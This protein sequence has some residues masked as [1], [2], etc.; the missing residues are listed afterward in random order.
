M[1]FTN[2]HRGSTLLLLV[3]VAGLP[4]PIAAAADKSLAAS[5]ESSSIPPQLAQDFGQVLQGQPVVLDITV[6]NKRDTPLTIGSVQ[7]MCSCMTEKSD[8]SIAPGKT[9]TISLRLETADYSGPVTEAA[10]IQWVDSAVPVTRVELKLDVKPVLQVLPKKL[11]RFKAALGKVVTQS[12]DLKAADG[13]PFKVTGVETSKPFL[14]AAAVAAGA[15]GYR[16]TITLGADAPAGMLKETVTVRTDI[17]TLPSLTLN[18]TGIVVQERQASSTA[19]SA[20]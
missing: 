14:K 11:V 19:G 18:V 4:G 13:K 2:N 12:V 15:G 1:P 17:P 8:R 6:T 9:G 3:L 10:L 20:G 16:L 5:V 7:P